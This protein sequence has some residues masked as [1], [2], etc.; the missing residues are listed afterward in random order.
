MKSTKLIGQDTDHLK[1]LPSAYADHLCSRA[2][3][4]K[5][6]ESPI[7]MVRQEAD[8]GFFE[9]FQIAPPL[10]YFQLQN[11]RAENSTFK[12]AYESGSKNNNNN[13]R[14]KTLNTKNNNKPGKKQFTADTSTSF[15]AM[16]SSSSCASSP[17]QQRAKSPV[18]MSFQPPQ[19]TPG[20]QSRGQPFSAS[21]STSNATP[22]CYSSLESEAVDG[23]FCSC[24]IGSS[25]IRDSG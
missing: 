11:K 23:N 14:S 8:G 17:G 18:L 12:M 24:T 2:S 9:N 20:C 4:I 21:S 15:S 7:L 6:N 25:L 16:T 3:T 5:N 1:H 19:A 10:E 22:I 13:N